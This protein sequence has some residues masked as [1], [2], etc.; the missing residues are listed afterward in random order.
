[1]A[2]TG[3]GGRKIMIE[4]GAIN[5]V[6]RSMPGRPMTATRSARANFFWCFLCSPYASDQLVEKLH[7]LA[8]EFA[9]VKV[10][11]DSPTLSIR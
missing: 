7:P 3:E 5:I 9:K 1:M 6:V 4:F 11:P 10:K 8:E 2:K